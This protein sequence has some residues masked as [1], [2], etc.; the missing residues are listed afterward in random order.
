[1]QKRPG[2][3]PDDALVSAALDADEAE[4]FVPD[5]CQGALGMPSPAAKLSRFAAWPHPVKRVSTGT[6]HGS[7]VRGSARAPG[8]VARL[9]Y[10]V[11]ALPGPYGQ[12]PTYPRAPNRRP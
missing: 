4:T 2:R 1:M 8:K 10:R 3:V 11:R 9:S 5:V 7:F 12:R 6:N